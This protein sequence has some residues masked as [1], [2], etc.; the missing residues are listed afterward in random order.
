MK[1]LVISSGRI[2]DNYGGGQVYVRNLVFELVSEKHNI[3]Y[4][5]L[6]SGDH[7]ASESLWCDHDGFKECQLIFLYGSLENDFLS[8]KSHYLNCIDRIINEIQ[9]DIIHAH[10]WKELACLAAYRTST[11]CIVTAHHGGIVC[12]AGA[13]LNQHDE[14]CGV[15]AGQTTC[16]PC[17]IQS[18]PGGQLW[19]PLLR[20]I[21]LET[22][23][24]LGHWL[25]ERRFL[26]FITPLGTLALSIREKLAAIKTIGK[27]A[28]L[29]IAPTPAIRDALVRN[30]IPISKVVVVPHGIPLPQRQ[31]LRRDMGKGPIRFMY[32]GRISHVK[33]IHVMLEAFS[34]LSPETYELHIVGGAVTKPEQ[35]YL[36]RLRQQYKSVNAIWHG[37]RSHEEIAQQIGSCDVTIHP[38]ICLEVF[39]LTIAES[40]AVGRPVIASRCGGAEAQI[41]DGEN[42]LL[43]PPNDVKA[44]RQAVQFLIDKPECLQTMAR[45]TGDVVPIEQH[46]RDLEKIY[47]NVSMVNRENVRV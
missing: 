2:S 3:Y 25:R 17:S 45:K 12:P 47:E 33:G 39:G 23:L 41:R 7:A 27:Y 4:L 5:S 32:V 28:T 37:A 15:P 46:V 18:I 1:I 14:I 38:A 42:G 21:P 8:D 29:L 19:W 36:A 26:Y 9:P 22:Q 11:P 13:L 43:V 20:L 34:G 6:I 24:R 44:L 31:P 40:L 30:G 16:P 35:R 10:G